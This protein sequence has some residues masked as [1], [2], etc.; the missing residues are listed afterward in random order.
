MA[1]EKTIWNPDDLIT[2]DKMNK[3]EIAI[4]TLNNEDNT[5]DKKITAKEIA[6]N[7][8][9]EKL[10]DNHGAIG[11][12]NERIQTNTDN[13]QINTINIQ[14]NTND[15]IDLNSSDSILSAQIEELENKSIIIYKGPYNEEIVYKKGDI[16][17]NN[18]NFYIYINT[19]EKAGEQLNNSTYW[20]EIN[21]AIIN[22]AIEIS[23][24]EPTNNMVKLWINPSSTETYSVPT[25][26]EFSV[27]GHTLNILPQSQ[28]G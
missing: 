9:N 26:E 16:V 25:I 2:S 12:I 8:I 13:I 5:L 27:E 10:G 21:T 17:S 28:G 1:Y 7:L 6:I 15:I 14:T 19:N 3:I 20:Q 4:E 24:E 18:A 11:T 22:S 23:N